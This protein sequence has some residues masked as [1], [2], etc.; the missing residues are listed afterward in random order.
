M[1]SL[2]F[3][4]VLSVRII[5]ICGYTDMDENNIKTIPYFDEQEEIGIPVRRNYNEY[6]IYD[7]SLSHY[8]D[9]Y[10]NYK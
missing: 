10:T 2:I 3:E 8:N 1:V 6:K 4:N 9:P 7:K 5:K